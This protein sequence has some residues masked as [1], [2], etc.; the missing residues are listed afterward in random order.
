MRNLLFGLL[1]LLSL[2]C[3][4]EEPGKKV[5]PETPGVVVAVN[6]HGSGVAFVVEDKDGNRYV[7]T[8]NWSNNPGIIKGDRVIMSPREG[9]HKNIDLTRVK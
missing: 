4:A 5:A 6:L 8:Y 2:G 3:V 9:I 1:V 7:L